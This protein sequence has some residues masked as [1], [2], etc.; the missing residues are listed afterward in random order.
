M[1]FPSDNAEEFDCDCFLS[2][3][4]L[5]EFRQRKTWGAS[6]LA[7]VRL[8]RNFGPSAMNALMY[9]RR[10]ETRLLFCVELQP[11]IMTSS[12]YYF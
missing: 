2:M 11:Y 5:S 6:S 1:G 9:S 12:V 10:T 4:N 8:R 3:I 7:F